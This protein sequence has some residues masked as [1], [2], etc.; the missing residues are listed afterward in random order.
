MR[1]WTRLMQWLRPPPQRCYNVYGHAEGPP[2]FII[3]RR[4]QNDEAIGIIIAEWRKWLG[5]PALW[6][7]L[8]AE[9][10][11][12]TLG[13]QV[14]DDLILRDR[15]RTVQCL[16]CGNTS[17]HYYTLPELDELGWRYCGQCGARHH[18]SAHTEK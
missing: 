11:G 13:V 8:T 16:H 18:A 1:L 7:R 14:P 4:W 6:E 2:S 3:G 9:D 5:L 12:R 10:V 17:K 15:E